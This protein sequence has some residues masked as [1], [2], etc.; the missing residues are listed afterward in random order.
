MQTRTNL[1]ERNRM[2]SRADLVADTKYSCC[3]I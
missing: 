1:S 3:I 2:V